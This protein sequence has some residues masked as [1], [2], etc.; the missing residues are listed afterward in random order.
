MAYRLGQLSRSHLEDVDPPLV[1]CAERAIEI[2]AQDFAVHEGLR[3][4]ERQRALF[5]AGASRTMDSY[6][7]PDGYGIGHA[8]DLVPWSAGKLQWQAQPVNQIA[9]AMRQ[10]SIELDYPLTW[11]AVWDRKLHDLKPDALEREVMAYLRR[12]QMQHGHDEYP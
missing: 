10:A 9:I 8:L 3:D 6:H 7:L 2:T 11:G 5:R 1:R 12:Y 4:I